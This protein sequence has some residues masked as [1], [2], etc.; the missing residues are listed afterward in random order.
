MVLVYKPKD[1]AELRNA[2]SI[3]I[4]AA[5][6][7]TM[8]HPIHFKVN[9]SNVMHTDLQ[10]EG[11]LFTITFQVEVHKKEEKDAPDVRREP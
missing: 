8:K 10:P 11:D 7:E 3:A 1:A 6:Q 9:S 5:I 2:I 4:H